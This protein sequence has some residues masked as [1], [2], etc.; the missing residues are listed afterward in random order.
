MICL[1]SSLILAEA[2]MLRRQWQADEPSYL[3]TYLDNGLWGKDTLW[4]G[5]V[6]HAFIVFL[7]LYLL[8]AD[9]AERLA[10]SAK[11]KIRPAAGD[12]FFEKRLPSEA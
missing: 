8:P 1:T 4:D 11:P 9:L 5:L 2:Q 6:R 3:R 10:Q 12:E 7:C